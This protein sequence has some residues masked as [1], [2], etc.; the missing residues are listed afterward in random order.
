MKT[1]NFEDKLIHMTK[2]EITELQHQEMLAREILKAKDKSVLSGWWLSISLYI[3]AV[4]IMK[5]FFMP[6]TTIESNLHDLINTEK[7]TSLFFFLS[8]PILFIIINAI[9]IRRIYYLSGSPKLSNFFRLVW[10]NLLV[11]IVSVLILI[12]YSL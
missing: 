4:L 5:A 3:I 12:I 10:F 9:S 2:P 6:G 8:L 11:I 7:F 1:K